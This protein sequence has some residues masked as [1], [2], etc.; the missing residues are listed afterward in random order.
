MHPFRSKYAAASCESV[1][2]PC[3]PAPTIKR[4]APSSYTSLASSREMVCDVPYTRLESFFF[5]FLTFPLSRSI[6]SCSNTD[7]SMVIEPNCVRSILGF[8][9]TSVNSASRPSAERQGG[10]AEGRERQARWGRGLWLRSGVDDPLHPAARHRVPSLHHSKFHNAL[11]CPGDDSPVAGDHRP[12]RVCSPV[13]PVLL[14]AVVHILC[15]AAHVLAASNLPR[16]A[17]QPPRRS[18]GAQPGQ[19]PGT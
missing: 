7:P 13:A 11:K 1:T 8:M 9:F 14:G 3:W 15:V 17:S 16:L 5:R 2:L 12:G 6:T 18:L 10:G 4:L 19:S